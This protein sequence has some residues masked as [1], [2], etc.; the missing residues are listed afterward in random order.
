[1]GV[2]MRGCHR[3]TAA[4]AAVRASGGAGRGCA[5]ATAMP[6]VRSNADASGGAAKGARGT[7]QGARGVV[8]GMFGEARAFM[9]AGAGGV[10]RGTAATRRGATT[11]ARGGGNNN[12][13]G[14]N[15]GGG[16]GGNG[17]GNNN[18]G[19]SSSSNGGST[20]WGAYLH[21]LE[22]HP[23]ATK[24]ATSGFLNALGDL[25][26]QFMFDDAAN[27]GIDFR[28][29]GVFTFLGAA[30]VGPALHLWYGTLGK[31]VTV[32]G[33][34]GA[35][36][37]LIL[38]Q[39]VFA[40]AFLCVFLSSLFTINGMQDQI[41]PKL[42]QDFASTVVANWKIWIPF[43]FLNFRFVPLNLQVAAAN[44]VALLWNT[45]L[46]WASHKTVVEVAPA[47]GKKSKK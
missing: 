18:D 10:A 20:L 16:N 8:R 31:L 47:G 14:G 11:T 41:V 43:Q 44:V 12:G 34:A 6:L 25:F 17:G 5:R 40:P 22:K 35:A 2:V 19:G 23:L 3:A 42:K 36:I 33:S 32:K 26:A 38:D 39:G 9:R 7:T 1:M 21:A 24:C 15:G 29:A 13:G 30:L 27:K 4:A 46:S 45:Y 37:S 28:R